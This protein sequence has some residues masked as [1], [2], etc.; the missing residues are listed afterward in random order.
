MNI[1]TFT[2]EGNNIIGS[3]STIGAQFSQVVFEAITAKGNGPSYIIHADGGE[4][5]AAWVKTSKDGLE[6]LSVSFRGPFV[7]KPVYAAMFQNKDGKTYS[8]VWDEP[9][10][11]QLGD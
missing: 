2:K 8:L 10:E 4:L 9:T 11:Q 3:I 1:G 6:Y 7:T 5:G